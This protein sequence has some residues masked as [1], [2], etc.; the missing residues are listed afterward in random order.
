M[1]TIPF[2]ADIDFDGEATAIGLRAPVDAA[3]A[4]TK[5]YVDAN[6]EGLAWKDEVRAATTGNVTLA[7]PGTDTFD[8]VELSEGDRL[9]VLAQTDEDENGIYI[10]DSSSTPMVRSA[11]A[12]TF[13]KLHAAVVTVKLGTANGGATFRQTQVGGTIG[14]DELLWEPFTAGA[15]P[16]ATAEIKGKA[17]YA[18]Q[19]EVD[20]GTE[21]DATVR[22]NTLFGASWRLRKHAE[23]IGDNSNTSITV[24]HNLGHRDV[25]VMVRENT[26]DHR[27]VFCE[28][29]VN[30]DNSITLIFAE[31]PGSNALRAIVIG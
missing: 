6:I 1:P 25:V 4:A 20:A 7:N 5:A 21:D 23:T 26:G 12:D 10:F 2:R 16:D 13:A 31:A 14:S 24:T 27:E 17:R 29:R 9:L 8:G 30:N 28:K 22:P 3:D 15:T 19:A 11:D 18:T